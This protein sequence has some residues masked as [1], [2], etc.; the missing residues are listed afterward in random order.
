MPRS[1]LPTAF[2]A[3]FSSAFLLSACSRDEITTYRVPKEERPTSPGTTPMESPSP[4]ADL[5]LH[6]RTPAGWKELPA[7][8]MRVASFQVPGLADGTRP[9]AEGSRPPAELSVIALPGDAGGDLPNVNRW[10]GQ[11]G[12][13]PLDEKSLVAQSQRIQSPA[14]TL[15]VVDWSGRKDGRKTRLLG[16]ILGTPD[17]TWFFKL[18]GEETVVASAKPSFLQFLESLHESAP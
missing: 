14:G 10:R 5:P 8:G 1:I 13:E 16:A 3:V 2:L 7:T 11:L 18:V 6:W 15:L 17:A 12:L 9:A 4:K